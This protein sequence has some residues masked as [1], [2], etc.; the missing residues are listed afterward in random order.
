MKKLMHTESKAMTVPKIV[1]L[2][3]IG[4]LSGIPDALWRQFR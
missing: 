3:L 2:V 1:L 4:C